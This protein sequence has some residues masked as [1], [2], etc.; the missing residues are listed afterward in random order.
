MTEPQI[1]ALFEEIADGDQ[2]PLRVDPRLAQRR[3]RARLRWKRACAAGTPVLAAAA[4]VVVALGVGAGTARHASG[5]APAVSQAALKFAVTTTGISTLQVRDVAT[6]AVVGKV[7]LPIEPG[8]Q[9]TGDGRTYLGGVA[10]PNGRTYVVAL[11]R[12]DPCQSWLYQFG[13][14]SRGQPTSVTPLR[15]RPTIAGAELYGLAVSGN[16]QVLAFTSVSSGQGCIVR[17]AQP[18]RIGIMNIGTGHIKEWTVSNSNSVN[19]VSLSANGSLLLYSLQLG[20]SVAR[21][22]PA[23]APPGQAA[24]RGRTVAQAAQFGGSQWIS[25]AAISPDG[26]TVCFSV[27]PPGG[28]GPGRIYVADLATGHVRLVAGGAT[29]PGLI[30][31]DPAVHQLL[32]HIPDGL[33]RL[34]LSTGRLTDLPGWGAFTGPITSFGPIT[35]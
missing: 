4:A 21:I 1:R 18:S 24:D 12:P 14:N 16:G 26:S 5:P 8:S 29:Y 28:G 15:A 25:F 19:G 35:W 31:S 2:G 6:G 32:L 3:G 20:P 9:S 11:Y 7:N 33:A 22:I 13:V 30:A 27:Y 23:S 34:D 17:K 10:T